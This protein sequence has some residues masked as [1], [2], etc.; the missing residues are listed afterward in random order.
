MGWILE[1][2]HEF[3]DQSS[4]YHDTPQVMI[5]G[6]VE[7]QSQSLVNQSLHQEERGVRYSLELHRDAHINF[8]HVLF[9][10]SKQA[11]LAH[12]QHGNE[13]H[14][15]FRNFEQDRTGQRPHLCLF[16]RLLAKAL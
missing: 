3:R 10:V 9:V 2:L 8:F 15:F 16:P 12:T 4:I 11:L 14:F 5:E 13:W 6:Q 1:Q 7:Q